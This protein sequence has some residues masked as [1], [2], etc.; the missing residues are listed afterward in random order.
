M[1]LGLEHDAAARQG[2]G[3]REG[4]K[5]VINEGI[6]GTPSRAKVCRLRPTAPWIERLDRDVLSH[7]GVTDVVLFMGTNDIR[8]GATATSVIEA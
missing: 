2:R 1:R 6:G 7:H 8:R 3:Q 4:L 5:A